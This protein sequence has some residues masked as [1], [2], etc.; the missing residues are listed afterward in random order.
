[1]PVDDTT[2]D[3]VP[4]VQHTGS[5]QPGVVLVVSNGVPT[6]K[7]VVFTGRPIVVGRT[8]G[9]LT[10]PEDRRASSRHAELTRDAQGWIVHDLKSKNGTRVDGT[11]L[12]SGARGRGRLVRVGDSIVLLEDDITRFAESH[13]LTNP[14]RVVGPALHAVGRL[15]TNAARRGQHVLIRGET[16]VGKGLV[17]QDFHDASPRAS[18]PFGKINCGSF[19]AGV[20]E[21]ELFGHARGAFSGAVRDRAGL[22]EASNGGT[23]FLDEIGDMPLA[24]QANV[25]HVIQDGEVRRIGENHA[26]KVQVQFVAATHRPLREMMASGVFRQ[27]LYYRL[28][29]VVVEIPPL[30]AR[31]EEIPFLVVLVLRREQGALRAEPGFYEQ[32][33]VRPW[34][35]NV[36]ELIGTIQATE[37]VAITESSQTMGARHLLPTAGLPVTTKTSV[38]TMSAGAQ[39]SADVPPQLLTRE[40]RREAIIAAYRDERDVPAIAARF[41]VHPTTVYR[42]VDGLEGGGT[43]NE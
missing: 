30:R 29:Q 38:N 25:L 40:Q 24:V 16:G 27:D 18:G 43:K 17:A 3:Q 28:A 6:L 12:A 14:K 23:V 21:D 7:T 13:E 33:L 8:E 22:F 19:A 9:T 26:R 37:T 5:E 41:R 11:V 10:V 1:M 36:R 31:R 42:I 35:G 15:V 20:L 32:L 34:P 39:M 2:T 4:S